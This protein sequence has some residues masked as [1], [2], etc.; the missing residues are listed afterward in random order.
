M[1]FGNIPPVP[2]ATVRDQLAQEASRLD[3]AVGGF[4]KFSN[5][6]PY[7]GV[8]GVNWTASYGAKGRRLAFSDAVMLEEMRRALERAQFDFPVIDF[9]HQ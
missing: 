9:A 2:I 8:E 5:I 6:R 4:H 1:P 7:L 3:R